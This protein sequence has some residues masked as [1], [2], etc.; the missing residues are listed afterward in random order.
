MKY[1]AQFD[2]Q[3]FPLAFY[4]N[5]IWDASALPTNAVLITKAQWLQF[6][7]NQGVCK[8]VNGAVVQSTP[9][10]IVPLPKTWTPLGFKELF[11][12]EERIAMRQFAK[13]DP[14]AEDWLDLINAASIVEANDPRLKAGLD[15]MLAKGVL[16]TERVNAILND[17]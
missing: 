2:S 6:I 4:T 17:S 16:S 3:G 5:D 11:A 10:P 15:Y 13:T 7:N 14:I 8:W 12:I 1:Y 9:A